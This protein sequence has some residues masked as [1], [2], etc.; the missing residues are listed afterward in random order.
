MAQLLSRFQSTASGVTHATP[1][2]LIQIP[3]RTSSPR[4]NVNVELKCMGYTSLSGIITRIYFVLPIMFYSDSSTAVSIPASGSY[5]YNSSVF[6][7]F[8]YADTVSMT[9]FQ[10]NVYPQTGS[11]SN[12]LVVEIYAPNSGTSWTFWAYADI[13]KEE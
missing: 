1:G 13:L 6:S 5:A 3:Y 11:G 8:D 2:T 12:G 7:Q 10:I 4:T 9:S